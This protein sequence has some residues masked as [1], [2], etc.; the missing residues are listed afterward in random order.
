MK[1]RVYFNGLGVQSNLGLCTP[2]YRKTLRCLFINNPWDEK[3]TL[4]SALARS[5]VSNVRF[6]EIL[7]VERRRAQRSLQLA[8]RN[9]SLGFRLVSILDFNG[10]FSFITFNELLSYVFI[11]PKMWPSLN[12]L[13]Y[14]GSFWLLFFTIGILNWSKIIK[15]LFLKYISALT[16]TH[17]P[18]ERGGSPWVELWG[19]GCS[20]CTWE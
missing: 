3:L 5:N 12:S 7:D 20:Q 13:H 4:F 9:R 16:R 6:V 15:D 11:S 8:R 1:I 2:F 18:R 10:L 19:W 14:S 17:K